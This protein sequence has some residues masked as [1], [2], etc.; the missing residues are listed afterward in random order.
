MNLNGFGI[1]IGSGAVINTGTGSFAATDTSPAT[2]NI[3][4]GAAIT[5][6][7]ATLTSDNMQIDGTLN[8]GAGSIT[9]RQRTN[10]RAMFFGAEDAGG[11]ALS[12]AELDHIVTTGSVFVGNSNTG[13]ITVNAPIDLD[14]VSQVS[15]TTGSTF[16]Q[17]SGATITSSVP[18]SI[19]APSGITLNAPSSASRFT[20]I[21][22]SFAPNQLVTSAS[23]L[24][25]QTDNFI[26]VNL[27]VT[28]QAPSSLYLTAAQMNNLTTSGT[29]VLR[30]GT[31][32]NDTLTIRGPIA[33][34]GTSTLVLSSGNSIA[35]TRRDVTVANLGERIR[36]CQLAWGKR[37]RHSGGN[38]CC[39]GNTFTFMNAATSPLTMARW[40]QSAVSQF[41]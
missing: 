27:G 13:P 8:A 22:D 33:P 37:R 11:V 40:T 21:T 28:T 23:D 34:T 35:Q 12:N 29:G 16:T 7:G 14:T 19:Y 25:V 10:G 15:V 6:S 38:L 9:L 41:R 3:Q 17:N 18:I 26:P 31:T 32:S 1:N 30:I 39:A 5:S 2:L 36:R 24:I 4:A 20:F